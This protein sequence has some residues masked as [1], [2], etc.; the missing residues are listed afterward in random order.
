VPLS[1]FEPLQPPEAVQEVAL[2]LDQVSAEEAPDFTLLGLALR[3][4]VGDLPATVTVADWVADPPG[5]VQV[6]ANSVVLVSVPDNFTPP[7][8]T[9]PLQPPEAV[10]PVAPVELHTRLVASPLLMV[11]GSTL[12]LTVGAHATSTA[13]V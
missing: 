4:T 1:A 2:V 8:E 6:S 11:A 3:V 10:Q 12:N 5:P 9:L 7:V 13:T